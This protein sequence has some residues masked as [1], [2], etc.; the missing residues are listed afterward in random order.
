[1]PRHYALIP[2]A[3]VGS[4]MQSG[5]P[6][7]YLPLRGKPMLAHAVDALVRTP[8]IAH[9][10]V[11]VSADDG[12]IDA[13]V[14]AAAWPGSRVGVLRVGGASRQESVQ[15]GVQAIRHRC[16]ADDWILVHD[17][18]RPGLTPALVARLI[19]AV[20]DDAVGGLLAL[21][22]VDT[23]KQ[24]DA[25]QRVQATLPRAGLWAAQTPQ[26]FRCGL[27]QRALHQALA[28]AATVTDEASAIEA[29]GLQPLLVQGSLCNM[30]VTLPEDAALAELFLGMPQ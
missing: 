6:K 5:I 13:L 24:A 28:S 23:M 1:M 10:F 22:V 16:A 12:Y 7:Q 21:P 19:D 4:R 20:G 15:N 11:V 8:D 18:A 29:L 17:A 27:L 26:M 25:A 9:V 14:D 3:G 30:K 2:A